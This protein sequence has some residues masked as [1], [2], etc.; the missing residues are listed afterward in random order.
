MKWIITH[1]GPVGPSQYEIEGR[2]GEIGVR[3]TQ[4]PTA[5]RPY[6]LAGPA[7]PDDLIGRTFSRLAEAKA[8]AETLM[9]AA[10]LEKAVDAAHDAL[11]QQ[12][13]LD[14]DGVR[15]ALAGGGWRDVEEMARREFAGDYRG[16]Y[17]AV[18]MWV[19]G[20]VAIAVAFDALA[21]A[22]GDNRRALRNVSGGDLTATRPAERRDA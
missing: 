1:R 21:T 5:L 9:S 6:Y 16:Y 15:A 19:L 4:H 13:A 8:V 17:P 20:E 14:R 2:L 7:V 22:L 18:G 3:R 11:E 10:D 12:L